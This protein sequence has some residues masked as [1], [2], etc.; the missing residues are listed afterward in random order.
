M[1]ATWPIRGLLVQC[2][3]FI[4]LLF[5]T[6]ALA[7]SL[8]EAL[9]GYPSL[10]RFQSLL[11]DKPALAP[12]LSKGSP[13]SVVTFL[14]PNDAAFAAFRAANGGSDISD[15]PNSELERILEYHILSRNLPS[16]KLLNPP[17]QSLVVPTQLTG[18]E[19]NNRSAGDA[20]QMVEGGGK[21][22]SSGQVVVLNVGPQSL[23]KRQQEEID[24]LSGL[25][26]SVKM[27]LIDGMWDGGLF[28]MVDG[29]LTLPRVCTKTI[30]S[31]NLT[32]LTRALVRTKI[33][34]IL[35]T[36]RNVTCIGPTDTA[37]EQA[38]SPDKVAEPGD[39][40]KALTFHT[41]TEPVYTNFLSDGQMFTTVSND[42]IRV[43]VNDTG[44]YFNDAKLIRRNVIT[45]NGVIQVVDKVMSPLKQEESK[46]TPTPTT[47]TNTNPKLSPT[48][49]GPASSSKAGAS[50]LENPFGGSTSA[51]LTAFLMTGIMSLAAWWM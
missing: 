23:Q 24:V 8:V 46:P 35:D 3:I 41:L 18:E 31:Q 1:V 13:G 50:M 38:D 4:P 34:P 12:L 5:S 44:I 42:T 6:T 21:Q 30:E 22:S 7:E 16:V 25:Y 47:T 40:A 19:Y 32:A 45:N 14:V 33:G 10:S 51:G 17:P 48:G 9:N 29:L 27:T 20:L 37:F 39:L 2:L 26:K 15:L 28:H 36:L 11:Q 49:P 43:T